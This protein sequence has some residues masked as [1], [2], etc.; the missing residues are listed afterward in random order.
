[1]ESA[2]ILTS[3]YQI[4]L[5]LCS[6]QTSQTKL[7]HFQKLANQSMLNGALV[8]EI[9]SNALTESNKN[10]GRLVVKN[11]FPLDFIKYLGYSEVQKNSKVVNV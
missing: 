10:F 2:N 1:M 8:I 4:I 3:W 5:C 11:I 7:I 6:K 9:V